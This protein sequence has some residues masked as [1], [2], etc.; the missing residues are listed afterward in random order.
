MRRGGVGFWITTGARQNP[1]TPSLFFS[2]PLLS[3]ISP[4]KMQM[5]SKGAHV[6]A[7][8]LS[9]FREGGAAAASSATGVSG[10]VAACGCENCCC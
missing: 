8:G 5:L 10:A 4:T 9:F 6:S 1:T 7:D 2:H 3:I